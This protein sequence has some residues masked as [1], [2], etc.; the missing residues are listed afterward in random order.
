MFDAPNCFNKNRMMTAIAIGNH[1]RY[2]VPNNFQDTQQ[3]PLTTNMFTPNTGV[4]NYFSSR[5]TWFR[6]WT[7]SRHWSGG[8]GNM[9]SWDGNGWNWKRQLKQLP[10][11]K[12]ETEDDDMYHMYH[13]AT[14]MSL[15]FWLEKTLWRSSKTKDKWVPGL[16]WKW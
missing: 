10:R 9:K 3:C 4:V 15:M 6:P 5:S 16:H 8:P 1:G 7:C 13:P 14:Q 12:K 2:G 11:K